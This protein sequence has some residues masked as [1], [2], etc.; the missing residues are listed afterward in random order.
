MAYRPNIYIM[1]MTNHGLHAFLRRL[2]Y[3][4]EAFQF[5]CMLKGL[6]PAVWLLIPCSDAELLSSF[7]REYRIHFAVEERRFSRKGG[8]LDFKIEDCPGRAEIALFMASQKRSILERMRRL[9]RENDPSIGL[10]LGYPECCTAS[11]IRWS[12]ENAGRLIRKG[13]C[14]D[15]FPQYLLST[16]RDLRPFPFVNNVALT[17]LG[18]T[19]LS[20]VP[21]SPSCKASEALGHRYLRLLRSYDPALASS[22][23]RHLRSWSLFTEHCGAVFFR[24]AR[25]TDFSLRFRHFYGNP[26]GKLVRFLERHRFDILDCKTIA[27]NGRTFK[28][29]HAIMYYR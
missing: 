23:E 17:G 14:V 9:T 21:C 12:A 22:L 27:S 8:G 2:S 4:Q 13:Y 28:D 16:V 19:L 1:K 6:K 25:L 29:S 5:L 11:L 3:Q 20:H 26:G 24:N 15:I 10:P 18:L 7:S